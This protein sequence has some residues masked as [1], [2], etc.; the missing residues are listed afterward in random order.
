[1]LIGG[2]FTDRV[3]PRFATFAS[4]TG[5]AALLIAVLYLHSLPLMLVTVFLV[6]TVSRFY[7]PT[8]SA[9]LSERTPAHQQVMIFAMYRLALNVGSAAAP[10]LASALI[11]VSYQLLFW[12]DAV[13]AVV[14]GLIAIVT[15][16]SRPR[17]KVAVDP[18]VKRRNGYRAVLA[19]R[20]YVLY[21]LA[22]VVNIAVYMQYVSTLPLAMADAGAATIWYSSAITLNG[23]MVICCELLLTKLTQR[24]PLALVVSVGFGLLAVGQLVYALPWGVGVFIAGTFIWTVAEITAGPTMASYPG[25]IAPGPL[26]GRYIASMQTM[27][28]LGAAVG[29]VLGVAIYRAVGSAVWLCCAFGC[30]IGLA[31]ALAG[32]HAP[33]PTTIEEEEVAA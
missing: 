28:N 20:R 31:L 6:G 17:D 9:M 16:P 23:L 19:D 3:G 13:T 33:E 30:A 27:F 18:A 2:A 26:R 32:M 21:L 25:R 5:Y 1:V 29:P 22:V 12:C 11:A 4:M 24:L 14:Y 10:L 8:A 15:L 7:L